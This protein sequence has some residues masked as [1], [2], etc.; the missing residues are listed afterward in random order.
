MVIGGKIG[1]GPRRPRHQRLELAGLRR[2]LGPRQCVARI[3]IA[4][5]GEAGPVADHRVGE[6]LLVGTQRRWKRLRKLEHVLELRGVRGISFTRT[7]SA[8]FQKAQA[9]P[10]LFPSLP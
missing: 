6:L 9:G 8:F 3:R 5:R 4:G 10:A 1:F 2:V 7:A